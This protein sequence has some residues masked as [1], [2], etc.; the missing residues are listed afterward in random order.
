MGNSVNQEMLISV[1]FVL[2]EAFKWVVEVIVKVLL[3]RSFQL[4][5]GVSG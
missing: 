2:I 3:G 5:E 1:N 4:P